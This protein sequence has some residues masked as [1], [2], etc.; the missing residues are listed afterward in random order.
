MIIAGSVVRICDSRFT[1]PGEFDNV[2]FVA[3]RV[4]SHQR[5]LVSILKSVAPSL[6]DE[7]VAEYSYCQPGPSNAHSM[8][9]ERG[10][11]VNWIVDCAWNPYRITVLVMTLEITARPNAQLQGV[12]PALTRSVM[13]SILLL[14]D[15]LESLD[16]VVYSGTLLAELGALSKLQWVGSEVLLHDR[17]PATQL[18]VGPTKCPGCC[19]RAVRRC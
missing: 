1:T 8:L 14:K 15:G 12:L 3:D 11:K 13:S 7:E 2:A 19:H 4:I 17:H 6:T 9:Q 16:M 10:Y 18:A 5:A